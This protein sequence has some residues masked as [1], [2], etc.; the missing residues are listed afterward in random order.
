M[1]LFSPLRTSAGLC[2]AAVVICNDDLID[3]DDEHGCK[4][5]PA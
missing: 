1:K 5:S 3:G 2:R 4:D